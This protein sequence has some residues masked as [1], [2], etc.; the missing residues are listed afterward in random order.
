MAHVLT[1]LKIVQKQDSSDAA[2]LAKELGLEVQAKRYEKPL[3]ENVLTALTADEVI[4]WGH[5]CPT[6]YAHGADI[7]DLA[8]YAFDSVPIEVMRHWKAIKDNYI[9]DRYEIWTTERTLGTDP[10]LIGVIGQKLYLLARWGLESP[11][12]AQLKDLARQVA[13]QMWA[14]CSRSFDQY[15][16]LWIK[17]RYFGTLTFSSQDLV[18]QA[19]C[20][21]SGW[22]PK[23]ST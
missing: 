7:H 2:K 9:F 13:Q 15:G 22:S 8:Q 4:L 16:F 17:T 23:K 18:F 11:E 12:Q 21:I 6:R 3:A 14:T 5:H 10:L 19:A 20:R 1:E